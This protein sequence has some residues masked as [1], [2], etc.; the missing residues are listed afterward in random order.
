MVGWVR[1]ELT[2]RFRNGVTIRRRTPTR[3][4]SQ[5]SIMVGDTGFEPVHRFQNWVTASHRS[6][7]RSVPLKTL[8]PGLR[9]AAT[10]KTCLL[11]FGSSP[12]RPSTTTRRGL[13]GFLCRLRSDTWPEKWRS[14][15]P[16]RSGVAAGCRRVKRR[17]CD[18]GGSLILGWLLL[19]PPIGSRTR[20]VPRGAKLVRKE[21]FSPLIVPEP[22]RNRRRSISAASS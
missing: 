14:S 18:D 13:L 15:C 20:P 2:T 9:R 22:A 12:L 10:P 7:T 3:P 1:F 4:P 17:H 21:G 5:K 8:C 11:S 6:P 16:V 19:S